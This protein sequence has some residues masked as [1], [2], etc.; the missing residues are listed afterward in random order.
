MEK[1]TLVEILRTFSKDE[2]TSF[3]DLAASPYFNKKTNVTKLC[4]ALNKFAPA[5]PAE[6]ITKEEMWKLIFP[7]KKYNYGIMKNLIYDLNKLAVKFIELETYSQKSFDNDLNILDGYRLKNL[8]SLFIKKA[9]ETRK[10]LSA[11]QLD[12]LSYY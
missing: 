12:N 9:A 6:K 11:R 10:R 1:S 8:K 7:G 2:L 5:F 3:G 4:K